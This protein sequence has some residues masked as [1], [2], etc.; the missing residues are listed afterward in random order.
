M[1]RMLQLLVLNV[2]AITMV[3]PTWALLF[4]D[5]EQADAYFAR[6]RR[7][8]QKIREG[9]ENGKTDDEALREAIASIFEMSLSYYETMGD[10]IP[11]TQNLLKE[12]EMPKER[13]IKIFEYMIRA[14]L[15]V[16]EKG[17]KMTTLVRIGD[18]LSMLEGVQDYDILPMLKECALSKDGRVRNIVI[19]TTEKTIANLKEKNKPDDIAK[20]ITFLNEMKQAEQAK[21]K[22]EN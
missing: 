5:K 19:Q 20:F 21:E 2:I 8:V 16:I 18:L 11:Y 13:Q 22:G 7:V 4:K 6:E 9:V 12:V 10:P 1:K 14:R 3:T 15:A 17:E